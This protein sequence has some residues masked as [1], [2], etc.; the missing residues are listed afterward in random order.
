[1]VA[2]RATKW[3][4]LVAQN[5]LY[6]VRLSFTACVFCQRVY[7]H[8]CASQEMVVGSKEI[9]GTSRKV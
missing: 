5:L 7:V 1:M 8:A 2:H 3:K 4:Y 9:A 6:R